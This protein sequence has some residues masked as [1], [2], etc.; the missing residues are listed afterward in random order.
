MSRRDK[1]GTRDPGEARHGCLRRSTSTL[2]R[3]RI[4]RRRHCRRPA[5]PITTRTSTHGLQSLPPLGHRHPEW[6][7]RSILGQSTKTPMPLPAPR[8]LLCL[9]GRP[10]PRYHK[11]PST[12]ATNPHQALASRHPGDRLRRT[13]STFLIA[14]LTSSC[15]EAVAMRAGDS[16]ARKLPTFSRPHSTFP[17]SNA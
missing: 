1:L 15:R 5:N 10:S 16:P 3:P 17:C 9:S 4:H 8:A 2:R 6:T 13:M 11:D 12:L 7:R 14:I